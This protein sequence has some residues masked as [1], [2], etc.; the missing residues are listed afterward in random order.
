M[1]YKTSDAI[2][3]RKKDCKSLRFF[4]RFL[5]VKKRSYAG[6]IAKRLYNEYFGF[7]YN[8][9]HYYKKYYSKEFDTCYD[10]LINRWNLNDSLAKEIVKENYYFTL[11]KYKKD[12]LSYYLDMDDALKTGFEKYVGGI[13]YEN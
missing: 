6:R 13:K 5:K 11:R 9:K 1:I 12:R 8:V 4:L 3:F 10:F 7:K 2:F